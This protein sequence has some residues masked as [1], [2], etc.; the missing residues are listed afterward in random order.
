MEKAKNYVMAI[1]LLMAI[2]ILTKTDSNLAIS[3]EKVTDLSLVTN[4]LT[5]KLIMTMRGSEKEKRSNL[6]TEKHL[7]TDLKMAIDLVK[8]WP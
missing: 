3:L 2:R 4:S 7:M 1:D 6:M 8:R 5:E